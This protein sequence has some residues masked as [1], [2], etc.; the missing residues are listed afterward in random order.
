[1]KRNVQ[2]IID[3]ADVNS[4]YDMTASELCYFM[5]RRAKVDPVLLIGEIFEF[6]YAVGQRALRREL[7]RQAENK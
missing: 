5:D 2:R 6:G 7:E 3:S 4:L 1:M